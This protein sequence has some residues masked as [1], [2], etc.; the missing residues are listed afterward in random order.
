MRKYFIVK[1]P[2]IRSFFFY[3]SWSSNIIK[4]STVIKADT[5]FPFT[6]SADPLNDAYRIFFLYQ[7]SLA[8]IHE[9]SWDF[10]QK[11]EDNEK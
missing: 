5:N 11:S 2:P 8:Y 3:F 10:S 9:T 4:I 1:C 7:I 6:R